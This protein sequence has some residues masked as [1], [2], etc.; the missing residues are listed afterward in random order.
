MPTEPKLLPQEEVTYA[1]PVLVPPNKTMNSP[2]ATLRKNENLFQF[3]ENYNPPY[4]RPNRDHFGTLR[5]QR[6]AAKVIFVIWETGE[7]SI[8]SKYHN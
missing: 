5:S 2:K 8:N 6:D 7:M 1:E 4:A 3:N